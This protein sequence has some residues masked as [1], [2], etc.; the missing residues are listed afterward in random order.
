MI[1]IK[2]S[3][4]LWPRIVLYPLS[5]RRNFVVC[6]HK[7]L[8]E[9]AVPWVKKKLWNTELYEKAFSSRRTKSV[10]DFKVK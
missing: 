7:P 2:D 9:L 5:L 3:Y 8:L 4:F 1:Y 6:P 10:F